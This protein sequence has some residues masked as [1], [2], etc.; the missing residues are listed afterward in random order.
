MHITRI[1]PKTLAIA[2]IS[3]L[4]PLSSPAG[5]DERVVRLAYVEW[6]TAIA[7]NNL[8]KAVIQEKLGVRCELISMTA[9]EMWR[10]VAT[11]SADA[12]VSAW[13]PETHE[14]YYR[15]VKDDVVNLG[16]NLE[17]TKIG[18]VAPNV[19]AGRFTAGTGIR[20]RPY[21]DIESITDLKE[22]AAKLKHRIIGIDPEAGIM[23]KTREA[24]EAYGLEDEFRLI[25]GS[26]ISM[27]AELS[28]AIRHKKWIVVTGWLPHWMFAQWELKFLKD[29]KNIYGDGG[30]IATIVR[31][32][33]KQ[34]MPEVYDF[35]DS[36]SWKPEEMGRLMLWIRRDDGIFPYDEALRW[37]RTNPDRIDSWLDNNN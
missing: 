8:V 20:N 5:A 1:I 22:R 32:G 9:S 15:E 31:E 14:R 25:D 35:L 37:M 26:E 12:M 36:F 17:G 24:L 11:G 28:N 7:S 19:T 33:L 3:V 34:D 13:L 2:L 27:V 16:P 29:P 4:L 10:A 18:L 30:H 23:I 21:M 6:S